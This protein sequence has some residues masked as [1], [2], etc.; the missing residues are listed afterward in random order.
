MLAEDSAEPVGIKF[1]VVDGRPSGPCRRH[2]PGVGVSVRT[3]AALRWLLP[4]VGLNSSCILFN[5][6]VVVIDARAHALRVAAHL[7][8]VL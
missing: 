1:L 2:A 8:P 3:G 5:V 6:A 7:P 4:M